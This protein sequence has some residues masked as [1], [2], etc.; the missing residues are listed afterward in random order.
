MARPAPP[1]TVLIV[2]AGAFGSTTAL[3]LAEGPYKGRADLI[4]VLDRA[5]DPPALDA[6]CSDYNKIVRAD[7]SD[8][9]YQAFGK[10][11]IEEW[12]TLRWNRHFHE[13]GVVVCAPAAHD[14]AEYVRA[15]HQLNAEGKQP[16][17]GPLREEAGIREFYPP[18]TPLSDF[19][20]DIG[21]KN[22]V[23]G[24]CASRDAT[25]EAVTLARNL[26]VRF[27]AAE[28]E[29]L[30]HTD[31][32]TDVIG[33]KAFDGRTYTADVVILA[34][35][36]WT[37][38]LLPELATNCL[39][40]GQV[41]ATVQ[42]DAE[43]TKRYQDVP[44]SLFMD[45][46]F[47][48]FP[49]NKDG[50]LKMA[51][52]G[53]GWLAPSGGLPS[54]PRTT[55]SSGFERQQ[56]PVSALELLKAGMRRVMPEIAEK[57]IKETR[58]YSD[59]ESGDFLFDWHPKYRSLFVAAGDSGHAMKFLPLIGSWIVGSLTRTLSPELLRLW[60]YEIDEARIDKSRPEAPRKE[61]DSEEQAQLSRGEKELFRAKL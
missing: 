37:P 3:A 39:P 47:Y 28:A 7:Y 2:G 17:V 57:E 6:A 38:R 12:R 18:G 60:A 24:W 48:T 51:I 9:I 61:L 33:V 49:P 26:G 44:V 19:K 23:G 34:C 41:V 4:T 45:S 31:D 16:T 15:S 52:H 1:Q 22:S 58:L 21:Y 5:A 42:L 43:E 40:T 36:S 59:R 11:A 32:G 20:G 27:L 8:E 54:F 55:L 13:C 50:I 14:Q 56:I 30:L 53:R 35:G 25:V 10:E 46:G 29:S